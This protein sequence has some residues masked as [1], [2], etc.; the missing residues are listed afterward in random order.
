MVTKK[1][2]VKKDIKEKISTS[3]VKPKVIKK[4]KKEIPLPKPIPEKPKK[5]DYYI[6][7]EPGNLCASHMITRVKVMVDDKEV[8][9]IGNELVSSGFGQD[10][11]KAVVDFIR[12]N[13]SIVLNKIFD[14]ES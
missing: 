8:R 6:A 4:V 14:K 11:Q 1:K 2:V 13:N 10:R 7:F 5:I 9:L 3:Q 12:R